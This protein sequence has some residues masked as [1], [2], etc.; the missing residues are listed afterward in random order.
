MPPINEQLFWRKYRPKTLTNMVI[1][2]RI[3]KYLENGFK[4]NVILHGHPGTGKSTIVDILLKDKHVLKI[5]ASLQ[6]GIDVLRENIL[7]FCDT[8][9]SPFVKTTDKMKYVYL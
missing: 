4:Q 6:N 8:L 1:L 7:E 5:N 9:P 2:P 3:K